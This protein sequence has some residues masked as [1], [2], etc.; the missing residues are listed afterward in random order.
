MM[1]SSAVLTIRCA[2]ARTLSML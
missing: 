1:G 2:I